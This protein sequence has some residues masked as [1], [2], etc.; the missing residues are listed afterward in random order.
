MGGGAMTADPGYW[1][2]N[3]QWITAVATVV[4]AALG[5]GL[6]LY[7]NSPSVDTMALVDKLLLMQGQRDAAQ[8]RVGELETDLDSEEEK[9]KRAQ[10][11]LDDLL[12]RQDAEDPPPGIDD[13]LRLIEEKGD[14]AAAEDIFREIAERKKKEGGAAHREAARALRHLGALAF[15]HDSEKALAAYAEAVQLDPGDADGWN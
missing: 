13:A 9:R 4:I 3:W 10:T 1:S 15:L 5:V 12:A 7:L 8:S 2:R 11:A 14:S 6:P